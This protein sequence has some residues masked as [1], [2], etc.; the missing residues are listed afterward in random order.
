LIVHLEGFADTKVTRRKRN[1]VMN[2]RKM[3]DKT[4]NGH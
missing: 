2:Q 4:S 1:N 3:D